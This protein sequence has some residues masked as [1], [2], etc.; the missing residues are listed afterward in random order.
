MYMFNDMV[1]GGEPH[2]DRGMQLLNL[3]VIMT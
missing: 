2:G 1:D 3:F